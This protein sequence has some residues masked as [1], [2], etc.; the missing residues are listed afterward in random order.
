MTSFSAATVDT[1]P[2]ARHLDRL[3]ALAALDGRRVIDVGCGDGAL[4]RALARRGAA[5]TGIEIDARALA[6]ALAAPLVADERYL[7]G[8]AEALPLG[9]A[10][11]DVV[12]FFNSLHHVP[13]DL[14]ARALHEAAR[15]LV[16]DGRLL[17]VEPIAAGGYFELTRLV[18]DETFVRAKAYEALGRATDYGLTAVA[19]ETYRN[20]LVFKDYTAFEARLAAVDPARAP[21]IERHRAELR[22]AFEVAA[23]QTP[24]GY[25]FHQP[26]R[27]NLFRKS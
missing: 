6:P 19:E 5:M 10:S 25:R 12:L 22:A 24:D 23:E 16:P 27:A 3:S 2:I 18:E 21:M 1:L 9:D 15:V 26:T 13:V 14:L 8:R 17:V 11:V 4:V 20:P 7:E